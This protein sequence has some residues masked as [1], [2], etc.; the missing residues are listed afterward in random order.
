MAE[1]NK[2]SKEVLMH[3]LRVCDFILV[4][5]NEYLDTHP[6]DPDALRCFEKH[7]AMR[8]ATEQAYISRYGPI[9]ILDHSAVQGN[10]WR[11]VDGPWPWETEKEG[12]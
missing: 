4:E 11:W 1:N 5:L 8:E 10:Q 6:D 12:I 7:R 9:T 3:R 2:E